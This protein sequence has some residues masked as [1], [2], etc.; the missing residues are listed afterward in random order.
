M[1]RLLR[2]VVPDFRRLAIM[3]NAGY[4][5]AVLEMRGDFENLADI[6]IIGRRQRT[7]REISPMRTSLSATQPT[8][9]VVKI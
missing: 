4:P 1:D 2:E 7:S 9:A 8:L 6:L 3:G 5:A